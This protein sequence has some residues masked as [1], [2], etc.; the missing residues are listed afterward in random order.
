MQL[1]AYTEDQLKL[2]QLNIY[3]QWDG[4]TIPYFALNG[5]LT[6]FLRYRFTTTRPQS[7]WASAAVKD[8]PQRYAQPCNSGSAAYFSPTLTGYAWREVANTPTIPI[9]I[10][11]GELKAACC[12]SLGVP[13]IGLGGVNNWRSSTM[14][15]EQLLPELE[16]FTWQGRAV[17]ILF[18]SDIERNP[19]VAAAASMLSSVLTMRGSIVKV[20]HPPA[21][22][23]D[24]K[25]GVDDWLYQLPKT[26]D[27]SDKLTE[28]LAMAPDAEGNAA[29]HLVNTQLARVIASKDYVQLTDGRRFA[30]QALT[31]E[32]EYGSRTYQV[33]NI[34]GSKRQ[35]NVMKT[36][37]TWRFCR[38]LKAYDYVPGAPS[39]TADNTYN[40][41]PGWGAHPLHGVT[42]KP[43]LDMLHGHLMRNCTDLER[44]WVLR[45]L[46]AP[47]QS[48]GLKM[49]SGVVLWSPR[50]GVGKTLIGET[51][52]RIYGANY[53][54]VE[55]KNL[56]SNFNSYVVRKQFIQGDE[57]STTDK[58]T[59]GERLKNI[60][61][62]KKVTV[63]EK[64]QIP[65]TIPD[66]ANYFFTSNY[67]DAFILDEDDRRFFVHEIE[68]A[69]LSNQ[70]YSDYYAWLDQGGG[71]SALF[72][73]LLNYPLGDFDPYARPPMTAAKAEMIQLGH[74]DVRRWIEEVKLDPAAVLNRPPDKPSCYLTTV[75]R[76]VT[77]YRAESDRPMDAA[78]MGK[79]LAKASVR[80]AAQGSPNIHVDGRMTRVHIVGA[81]PEVEAQLRVS[82]AIEIQH[83]MDTADNQTP[84]KKFEQQRT[85]RRVQ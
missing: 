55:S 31:E 75:A 1:R 48:P 25:L 12:C 64:F 6:N 45:W 84:Q 20:T 30:K 19:A 81:P 4:F 46:A 22:S 57:N 69:P 11:E 56:H 5:Q 77:R 15:R 9:V 10:T 58:R 24:A 17:I 53:G 71:A 80:K 16:E 47:L 33:T 34:D 72:D 82:R 39:V 28:L 40:L 2:A 18:D 65:Y 41:W 79:E 63:E 7:G 32:S 67:P 61:S 35:V 85:Q 51:M 13:T 62:N 23:V 8:K 43:F 14:D 50:H 26:D 52:E 74:T 73:F 83:L 27:P 70:A 36:W 78:W 60:I 3:P 37:L 54:I 76:L 66:R 21:T 59:V 29:L 38:E 44:Q 42:V 68:A 49:M